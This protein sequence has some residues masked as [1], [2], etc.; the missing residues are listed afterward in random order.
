MPYPTGCRP[1]E[2]HRYYLGLR[3]QPGWAASKEFVC[4]DRSA[5]EAAVGTRVASVTVRN[6]VAS[7]WISL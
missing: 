2:T 6:V 1:N 4:A 3:G 7:N 5:S